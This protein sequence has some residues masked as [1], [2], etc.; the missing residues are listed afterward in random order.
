[1]ILQGPKTTIFKTA[2]IA[3]LLLLAAAPAPGAAEGKVVE[4]A[5]AIAMHGT[6]KYPPGFR[7]FDYVNPDAP[8]GG[9]LN[10]AATGTF[11]ARALLL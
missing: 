9:S 8:K 3:V 10:L 11:E 1:M 7:Y 4:R 5:H 2:A 6:P